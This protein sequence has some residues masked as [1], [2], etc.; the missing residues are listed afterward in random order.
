M[1]D[2][3]RHHAPGWEPPRSVL[4]LYDASPMAGHAAW[5]AGM[6]ARDCGAV[7]RLLLVPARQAERPT[8][9]PALQRLAREIS[10]RLGVEAEAWPCDGEPHAA[11]VH[12]AR[13]AGLVVLGAQRGNALRDWFCGTPAERL[14]RQ[15]GRPVLLVKRP[16]HG[17]YRRVLVPVDLGSACVAPALAAAAAL[18]ASEGIEVFHALSTREELTLRAA[19]V[20]EATLRHYRQRAAERARARIDALLRTV[21]AIAASA[22]PA[23]GYGDPWRVLLVKEQAMRAEL[24]VMGKR[25]RG[26]LGDFF[27]GSVTQNVLMHGAADVLVLLAQRGPQQRH[28]AAGHQR[29]DEMP[30]GGR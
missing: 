14:L 5:R 10:S 16:A 29:V 21:P 6:V 8:D 11:V 13:G 24:V 7:L 19:E 30:V 12:A 23:V 3:Q 20:P 9:L 17:R 22:L 25:R 15:C 2:T 1:N 18:S 27:L 26:L 28:A 4:A